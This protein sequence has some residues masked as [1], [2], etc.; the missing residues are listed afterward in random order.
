VTDHR[1]EDEA[2]A[3]AIDAAHEDR[4]GD[5]LGTLWS[6]ALFELER[7]RVAGVI[8]RAEDAIMPAEAMARGDYAEVTIVEAERSSQATVL[9]AK[10]RSPLL[11]L[12]NRGVIS[13]EQYA[14]ACEIATVVERM[15]ATVG[16]RSASLEARVDNSG[17]ARDLLIETLSQVRREVA[18]SLWRQW[19]PYPKRMVID[20]VVL[21][22]PTFATARRYKMGLPKAKARLIRALDNWDDAKE[23][24]RKM[25]DEQDVL[26]AHQRAG[27]GILK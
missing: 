15:E 11:D 10:D 24:V 4:I 1:D 25:L 8:V 22:R 26:A 5:W 18:Y 13:D 19:L 16:I 6:K 27:G 2:L 21:Q 23:R 7:A 20:M 9:R 14:A 3:A 17:A 12:R